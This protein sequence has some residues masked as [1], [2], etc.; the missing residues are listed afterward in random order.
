VCS[1]RSGL[2]SQLRRA[3]SS[4]PANIAEGC[5]RGSDSD[6]KRFLQIAFGSASETEY[7]LVLS[8]DLGYVSSPKIEVMISN[9]EEIKKML[10]SFIQRIK[11]KD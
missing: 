10:S 3:S 8:K 5:G 4:I 11:N 7:L 2:S 9:V 1:S 6:F